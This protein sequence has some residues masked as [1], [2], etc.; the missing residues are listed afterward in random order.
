[1]ILLKTGNDIESSAVNSEIEQYNG[2]TKY[3][4][5]WFEDNNDYY[6]RY[7][8]FDGSDLVVITNAK[9]QFGEYNFG[10]EI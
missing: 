4:Y 1:V 2:P 10:C 3:N 7:D 5:E 9:K 8:D 6:T